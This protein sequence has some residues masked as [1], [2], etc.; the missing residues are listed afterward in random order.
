MSKFCT[1]CGTKAEL[2]LVECATCASPLSLGEEISALSMN[3]DDLLEGAPVLSVHRVLANYT[4]ACN[5]SFVIHNTPMLAE[6]IFQPEFIMPVVSIEALRIWK[7]LKG[8]SNQVLVQEDSSM[9]QFVKGAEGLFPLSAYCPGVGQDPS[10]VLRLMTFCLSVR[11]V[12]GLVEKST[13]ELTPF[14][15]QWDKIDWTFT[16]KLPEVW[17]PEDYDASFKDREF[18]TRMTVQ[19][20]Y[21]APKYPDP[22]ADTS[23]GLAEQRK[24]ASFTE[25]ATH[26]S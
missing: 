17:M 25:G 11:H 3:L 18:S 7:S 19:S 15:S 2:G 10:S 5:V 9:V 23:Q 26:S 4:K 13:I 6:Q 20:I 12:F 16:D 14:I 8:E 21:P 1:K 22:I 24:S